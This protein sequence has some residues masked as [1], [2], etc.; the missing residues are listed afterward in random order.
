MQPEER[1][2]EFKNSKRWTE[3]RPRGEQK[4]GARIKAW[5]LEREGNFISKEITSRREEWSK[6]GRGRHWG[7]QLGVA[8][9]EHLPPQGSSGLGRAGGRTQGPRAS[10]LQPREGLS[11]GMAVTQGPRASCE[12]ALVS[13]LEGGL[14]GKRGLCKRE[15]GGTPE[16]HYT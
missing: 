8:A 11:R 12:S 14:E 16:D 13:T 10:S 6:A 9:G 7:G 15:G 2:R 5:K 3:K 4:A 1:E